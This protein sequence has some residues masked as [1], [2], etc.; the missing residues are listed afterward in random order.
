V[1]ARFFVGGNVRYSSATKE[2]PYFTVT[3][4]RKHH[5]YMCLIPWH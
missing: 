1:Q 2:L 3:G 5:K 4:M